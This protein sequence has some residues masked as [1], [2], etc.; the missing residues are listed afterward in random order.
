MKEETRQEI[1]DFYEELVSRIDLREQLYAWGLQLYVDEFFEPANARL[2]VIK[3]IE[4]TGPERQLT[5]GTPAHIG[6]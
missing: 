1:L 3:E 4:Y 2:V 5:A 6:H